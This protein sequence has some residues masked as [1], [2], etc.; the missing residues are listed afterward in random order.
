MLTSEGILNENYITID[1][2]KSIEH[3]VDGFFAEYGIDVDF[4]G[5]FTHFIDR[6]ND[7]RNEAPIYMDELRDF[8]EDLAN[9]YGD[10]IA[11]QLRLDRPTGVGSDYHFDIR[12]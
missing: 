3:A 6:L 12:F 2:L 5:K 11:R 4:Q 10:K 8:F 7:P 9:E 1:E